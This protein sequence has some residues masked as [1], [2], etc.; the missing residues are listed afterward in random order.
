AG[1]RDAV[2]ELDATRLARRDREDREALL[3]EDVRVVRP[4]DV[5]A[6]LLCEPDQLDEPRER[7]VRQDRDAKRQHVLLPGAETPIVTG[8]VRLRPW[9]RRACNATSRSLPRSAA[10][11]TA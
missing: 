7:R 2:A 3:P 5:E 6:V 1:V 10:R 11:A 9:P 8:G 4:P